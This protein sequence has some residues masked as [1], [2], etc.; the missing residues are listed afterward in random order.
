LPNIIEVI[1]SRTMSWVG[2]V[3]CMGERE[4]AYRVFVGKPKGKKPFGRPRYRWEDSIEMD[5]QEVA[6]R[7]TDWIDVAQDG[8]RWQAFVNA[9]KNLQVFYNRWNFLT[10]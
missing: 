5:L 3:A 10:I 2:H 8:D 9:V 7:D 1:K 4:G 6:W